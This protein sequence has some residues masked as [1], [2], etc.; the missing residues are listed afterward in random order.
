MSARERA[1]HTLNH[2]IGLLMERNNLHADYDTQ[3]EINQIVDDII[4]ASVEAVE[5]AIRTR[6][7]WQFDGDS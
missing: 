3:Y 6:I 2:Y 5:K 1:Q 4:A 7:I